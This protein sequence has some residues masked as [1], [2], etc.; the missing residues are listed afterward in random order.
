MNTP[1][2]ASLLPL[3]RTTEKR[4]TNLFISPQ[5]PARVPGQIQL[6][7]VPAAD[8]RRRVGPADATVHSR[9]GPLPRGA[10]FHGMDVSKTL[11][12][13]EGFTYVLP[14][15]MSQDHVVLLFGRI[16]R[17]GGCNPK[18]VQLQQTLRRL[19]LHNF[20]W[21]SAI[22]NNMAPDDDGGMLQI[23]RPKRHRTTL[24]A[25]QPMPAVVQHALATSGSLRCV[26]LHEEIWC[27]E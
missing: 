27:S 19:L 5:A 8:G 22:G 11:L 26:W 24:G 6:H 15:K 14:Y 2:E 4:N 1:N 3:Q 21:P 7:D 9:S 12:E 13:E 20:I 25:K 16:R 23:R 18:V 10:V 17:M